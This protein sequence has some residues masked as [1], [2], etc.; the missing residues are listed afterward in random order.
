MLIKKFLKD[1]DEKASTLGILENPDE[2]I[3]YP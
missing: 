1:F 3:T 2:R